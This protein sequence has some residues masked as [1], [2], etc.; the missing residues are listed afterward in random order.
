MI[1][2][3]PWSEPSAASVTAPPATWL[4]THLSSATA[5]SLLFLRCANHASSSGSLHCSASEILLPRHS[6]ETLLY[7]FRSVVKTASGLPRSNLLLFLGWVHRCTAIR[8]LSLTS[9]A[10]V[11]HHEIKF[12]PIKVKQ[13]DFILRRGSGGGGTLPFLHSP[14]TLP[15]FHSVC[16]TNQSCCSHGTYICLGEKTKN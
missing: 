5:A 13:W 9:L 3:S 12:W 16:N 2:R 8:P 11:C 1:H 4:L 15:V 6:S 10:A 14:F 7:F